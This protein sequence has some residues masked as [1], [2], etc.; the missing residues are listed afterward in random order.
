MTYP[1]MQKAEADYLNAIAPKAKQRGATKAQ[2]EYRAK[3][4]AAA[5]LGSCETRDLPHEQGDHDGWVGSLCL[6]W[7][8]EDA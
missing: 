6:G 5:R 3:F 7:A 8:P 4:L 2:L 1:E